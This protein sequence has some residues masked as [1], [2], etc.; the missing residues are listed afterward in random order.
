L[1]VDQGGGPACRFPAASSAAGFLKRRVLRFWWVLL[2][3]T[4]AVAVYKLRSIP[5][6]IDVAMPQETLVTQTL[7]VTGT[8]QG[9]QESDLSPEQPGILTQLLVE[10]GYGVVAGDALAEVSS[11]VLSSEVERAT[12]ALRT[13]KARLGQARAEARAHPATVRQVRS[14]VNG[15]VRQAQAELQRVRAREDELLAGGTQEERQEVAAL[16]REAFERVAQAEREA[17]RAEGLATSDATARASLDSARASLAQAEARVAHAEVSVAETTRELRRNERLHAD[18]AVSGFALDAARTR[19]DAARESAKQAEA[20]RERALVDVA[21]EERLLTLTRRASLERAQSDLLAAREQLAAIRARRERVE[22]PARSEI[23]A[24]HRADEAAA[25][26]SLTTA[27]EAGAARLAAI[28]AE[29]VDERVR[30]AERQV[31]EAERSLKTATARLAQTDVLAPFEG[32]VTDILRR[33]GDAVGPTQP[34]LRISDISAP[35]IIVDIDERDVAVLSVGLRTVCIADVHP[36]TSVE[37]RVERIGSYADSQRGTI[38]VTVT[39]PAPPAWLRSGMTF[40]VTFVIRPE[41][42]LLIVPTSSVMRTGEATRVYLV[43]EGVVRL[44]QIVPGRGADKGTIVL[45]GLS[46]AD[47]V[48]IDPT[49]VSEGQK[50][51]ARVT[52]RGGGAVG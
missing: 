21:R 31:E 51:R 52:P 13:A 25:E 40:D 8:L 16:E 4:I 30:V 42:R 47:M 3:L 1:S 20:E 34:V 11:G 28:Q 24:Q 23:V 48:I 37:G 12:S 27:R 17:R 2:L 29:P 49:G 7:S 15:S 38:E 10:E 33:P 39:I 22:A 19:L 9:A 36:G 26:T 44:K 5:P 50:V 18:G 6:L 45:E 43:D 14:E 35:E 46:A 41:E 32:I